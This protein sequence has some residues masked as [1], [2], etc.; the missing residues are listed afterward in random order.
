M[1][2]EGGPGRPARKGLAPDEG[3]S[4]GV[5]H[6]LDIFFL[7]LDPRGTKNTRRKPKKKK[8]KKIKTQSET[9]RQRASNPRQTKKKKKKG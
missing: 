9:S 2:G 7:F 5:S 4:Q 8:I 3:V 1:N 6:R